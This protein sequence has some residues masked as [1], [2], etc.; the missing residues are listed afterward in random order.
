[1]LIPKGIIP[2]MVTPFT[3]EYALNEAALRRMV[4]RFIEK[5]V[6][7]LFCLGTNGEF[8]SLSMEEKVTI[9][10]VVADEA[11]GRVPIYMGAGGIST[12]ETMKL[13][14]KFEDI[15]IDAVS[16]ITPYFLSFT[17]KELQNHYMSLANSTS[18]PIVLY[19]IPAR[20]GNHLQAK[21]VAE[22]S[23]L[24]NIVGIKDS[25]GSFDNILAYISATDSQQFSVLAG[26]DSLILSTLLAGG[27][28][29]I[30][31]TANVFPA[32]VVS[33]YEYW[34]QG[35]IRKAEDAQRI[36]RAIRS[37]F[38]LGTLPSVLKEMMNMID[39]PA[40]PPRLPVDKL[41]EQAMEEL[42]QV[43]MTYK[44]QGLLA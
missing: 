22:L 44:E 15:G 42:K 9:A 8:F 34:R 5:G 4:N 29:A 18:L 35:D 41:S 26:T 39:L 40:G 19:N 14:R 36:L 23:K 37:A 6:H 31:S 25:S 10:E 21:T 17:Q 43:V 11:K 20:T 27:Q 28:G 24:P 1:M 7:G 38:G 32:E 3:E 13:T 12:E 30:A 16:V 33:I 2:A